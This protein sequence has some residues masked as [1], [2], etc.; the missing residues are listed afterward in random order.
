MSASVTSGVI[1]K[2][3]MLAVALL[4]IASPTVAEEYKLG[5]G[6][7][8][9]VAV[10]NNPDLATEA[11]IGDD[12]AIPFPLI[13]RVE[14]GGLTKAAAEQHLS[15]QLTER[16]FLREAAINIT[17]TEYRSQQVSVLGAV[18]RPGKYPISSA[19]SV[20]DILA[21]AGGIA[22]NGSSSIR[23]VQHDAEGKAVQRDIDL[24]RLVASTGNTVDLTV[25]NGD[26]IFVAQQP[27]FYIYGEVQKPGAYPLTAS[28]TVRQAIATGGGL[29]LRGT[30]RGLRVSR[31]NQAG[32]V[33]VYRAKLSDRLMADDVVQ[34]KESLF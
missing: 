18:T 23:L 26:V 15:K 25:R 14:I 3:L 31:R 20:L 34:V 8:V 17:V 9:R 4:C 30:E 19:T 28:M 11:R 16:G 12:G 10:Y 7:T 1:A 13:G 5:A 2:V 24:S 29:T 6:D 27:V 21:E 33:E 32:E 22:P